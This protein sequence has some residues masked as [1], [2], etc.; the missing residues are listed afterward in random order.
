MKNEGIHVSGH[1]LA[2]RGLE[3][4]G[5]AYWNLS[6]A[7]LYEHSIRRGEA[8]LAEH[9]PLVAVTGEHTGRSPNDRFLVRDPASAQDIWWGKVNVPFDPDRFETLRADLFGYL[10]DKDL[11]V[12]DGYAGADPNYRLRVRVINE[13]AW[14]NLFARNMFVR[15]PDG[16]V[17]ETFEPDARQTAAEIRGSAESVPRWA[18]V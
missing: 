3:T 8:R 12:F 4:S 9:G 7:G 15:E 1:T 16:S 6:P 18:Q 11:Y 10:R 2:D 14:H 13:F 17:L 5:T